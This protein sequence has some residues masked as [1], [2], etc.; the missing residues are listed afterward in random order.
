MI[1]NQAAIKNFFSNLNFN[2]E[3]NN[4]K[5]SFKNFSRLPIKINGINIDDD[6]I[7]FKKS[8]ILNGKEINSIPSK[9]VFFLREYLKDEDFNYINKLGYF[10]FKNKK[11]N[12]F[13]SF[14][15]ADDLENKQYK[16]KK[17]NFNE[18]AYSFKLEQQIN[19]IRDKDFLS[20][21][22]NVLT[23]KR[24]VINLY[25]PLII[26]EGKKLFAN[27][28]FVINFYNNSYIISKSPINL[29]GK[30]GI[31]IKS[32]GKNNYILVD[33]KKKS[34]IKNIEFYN[35]GAP[36]PKTYITGAIT[37]YQG[38]VKIENVSFY[39]NKSGDDYLNL[40][41]CIF[42]LKNININKSKFDAI[43]IDFSKGAIENLIIQN[44]GN[45]GLDISDSKV[46]IRNYKGLNILDKGLSV[47]EKSKV[48]ID[49]ISITN[50]KFG[51]VSKD[52]SKVN[53]EKGFFSKNYVSLSAYN[54]KPEYF[55][56]LIN[57]KKMEAKD[58]TYDFL[59]EE[60]SVITFKKKNIE[61]TKNINFKNFNNFD[62]KSIS[63]WRNRLY[64]IT[65]ST[66]AS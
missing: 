42:D 8:I 56:G 40:V 48:L 24:K 13:Y 2:S 28:D 31:K 62:E 44:A 63:Y 18:N 4:E 29:I 37:F 33:S 6:L 39:N 30:S 35:L 32:F 41:K 23:F 12:V 22:N 19:D 14:T 51:V 46:D 66:K 50:S 5:I 55:G 17:L 52:S 7:K 38:N 27:D 20:E 61:F 45:D 49:D 25:E 21:K 65:F 16:N 10:S 53:I 60:N 64:W 58:Y 9:E 59:V 57:I 54:K 26:P 3:I 1:Y 43:D 34:I 36:D 11:M 15:F 47:G